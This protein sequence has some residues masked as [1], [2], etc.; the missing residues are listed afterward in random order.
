[1]IFA[2]DVDIGVDLIIKAMQEEH[3]ERIRRQWLALLP[4]MVL[5]QTYIG[6]EDYFN[7]VTG[8]T[9]DNR[10]TEVILQDLADVEKEL[11]NGT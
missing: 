8:R 5:T 3:R 6:F 4:A 9:I 2:L 1:M 7:D 10:P 11:N